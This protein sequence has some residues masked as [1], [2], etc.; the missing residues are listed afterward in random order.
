[1][2]YTELLYETFPSLKRLSETRVKDVVSKV[3]EK[4]E[5]LRQSA[6][7]TKKDL[8]QRSKLFYEHEK[9]FY[10]DMSYKEILNDLTTPVPLS[11]DYKKP[12]HYWDYSRLLF[13]RSLHFVYPRTREFFP[14]VPYRFTYWDRISNKFKTGFLYFYKSQCPAAIVGGI[15]TGLMFGVTMALMRMSVKKLHLRLQTPKGLKPPPE[16]PQISPHKVLSTIRS[17]GKLL[18]P[19]RYFVVIFGTGGVIF[20]CYSIQPDYSKYNVTWNDIR[21]IA[22]GP[23][24]VPHEMLHR[25]FDTSLSPEALEIT[26][27]SLAIRTMHAL[28]TY[29]KIQKRRDEFAEL[30]FAEEYNKYQQRKQWQEERA[31]AMNHYSAQ[32]ANSK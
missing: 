2:S 1:M 19:S 10:L 26:H 22:V 29:K 3:K 20:G 5:E 30:D 13:Y 9:K 25:Y 24:T 31:K 21:Y 8:I 4:A 27:N 16:L 23:T 18:G 11:T 6:I 15:G 7:Y 17:I 28:G 12:Y 14:Y 32:I